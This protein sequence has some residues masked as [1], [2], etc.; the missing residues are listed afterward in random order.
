MS[1]TL[2]LGLAMGGGV[3]L[4]TFSGA[5]LSQS[6]KLLLLRG[7][8]RRSQ[9]YGRLEVDLFSGASAGSMALS[10]MLRGLVGPDPGREAPAEDRLV[11]EFGLEFSQL[12]QERKKALVAA[13]IL[14]DVQEE[15]W[16]RE[17]SLSRLLAKET[18]DGGLSHPTGVPKPP[19][20]RRPA[21]LG[22]GISHAQHR[23]RHAA[24][25]LDRGAVEELAR[26]YLAFPGTVDLSRRQLLAK[27][28]LVA[29]SLANL[30]PMVADATREY[31]VGELG[32]LGLSDGMASRVHR[33][34]RV[35]DLHFE[36]VEVN[37][38][39]DPHAFPLRWCRYHAGPKVVDEGGTGEGIG[40]L[41][42]DRGWA[43]MAATALASGSYP[44]VFEPVPL[45]RRSYEYG[46][47][48]GGDASLW[49]RFLQGKDRHVFTYVDGGTFL[50]EPVREAFRLASYIDAQ[51]PEE[52]FERLILFVDP[53]VVVP[54]PDLSLPHEGEWAAVGSGPL[55]G[56]LR[57]R[58]PERK[59]SLDRLL[60]LSGTVGRAIL[61]E[62]RVVEAD[63]VFQ[64]RKR[65]ELRNRIREYMDRA[66]DRRPLSSVLESL[67]GELE[68]LLAEDRAGLMIPAGALTLEGELRRVLREERD[69]GRGTPGKASPPPA[70]LRALWPK[71][72]EDVRAFLASPESVP[73]EELG[74]WLRALTFAAV[75]RVMDLEGKMERSRLVAI[76]PVRDPALPG[77]LLEL[78]GARIGGFGGFMSELAG[79]HEVEVGRHCA[80]LFLQEDGR[81]RW[82]SLPEPPDFSEMEDR[83]RREVRA[84]LAE[85]EDRLAR[86]LAE[87]RAGLRRYVPSPILHRVFRA[88]LAGKLARLAET[89]KETTWELRMQVPDMSFRLRGGR[90][91]ERALR[92]RKMG[93]KLFLV[94]F[95]TST[96]GEAPTWTGTHITPGKGDLTVDRKRW[97]SLAARRHCTVALPDPGTLED[98]RRLSQPVLVALVQESHRGTEIPSH[99][100]RPLD[101]VRGLEETILG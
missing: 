35:F 49:P 99:R 90:W 101:G 75:D 70:L 74:D 71:T 33:E 22:E 56:W 97:A 28:V 42:E 72:R 93:D 64:T 39:T 23:L 63:R 85:V 37:A 48:E 95:A 41:F 14:Q 38:L 2:R 73:Q 51:N 30:T 1:T 88:A 91:A 11:R 24:G 68:A 34:L 3:S 62:S 86:L 7:M 69:P 10:L 6:L 15:V 79:E 40:S 55:A 82:E 43:K 94:T 60:P 46:S 19:G 32:V 92:P 57:S 27:R 81:I 58:G 77:E 36:P 87:S 8:D 47:T 17:V 45:E 96:S 78:P 31:P 12:A 26:R 52:D 21:G 84:G 53:H 59:T 4:G 25:L 29:Y 80:Q 5:A 65:F 54:D 16:V 9:P 89:G 76:S 61:N 50:N 13:Q 83:Y 20:A 44:L 98:A 100:W 18:V 66:L 67:A